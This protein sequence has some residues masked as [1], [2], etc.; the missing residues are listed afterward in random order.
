MPSRPR[1][2]RERVPDLMKMTTTGIQPLGF[3]AD[4]LARLDA[5]SLLR[6][7]HS[8][9]SAQEPEVILDDGRRVLLLA[10][11]NYLGL[12]THPDVVEAAVNAARRWGAGSGSARLITGGVTPHDELE[13]RL[14]E[15]KGTDDAVVFS[16][17]YLAN[18]GT[19]AA[20]VGPGD[21]IFSDELNH[22]SII[23]GAR[24]SRADVHVYRH[25]NAGHLT[26]QLGTWRNSHP[27]SRALVV[28][29]SVFS[30]DGDIAPLGGLADACDRYGAI[31]MVDEA[32]ATGVI[33]P[34]GRGAVAHLE[35]NGRVPVIM[36]TLSKAL[37]A[38]GGFVSGSRELCDFL[39]N[40]ARAFIFDTAMPAPT[41]A[42]ASAA[43]DILAKE[44]ERAVRAR[45]LAT[46]LADKLRTVGFETPHPVAAIV[47][48]HVGSS[49]A[50]LQLA[51]SL[52][53]RGVLVPAIRPP[54]VPP[55]TARLR[56]TVMATH[57]DE[58]LSQAVS[59]F[60]GCR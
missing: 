54:T 26:D 47:P 33:G 52:M 50:A 41:A 36:G 49:E 53:D 6:K 25:A 38:A 43:L 37:G 39:R 46:Q 11:N 20:L 35:L 34:R 3:C 23:D 28:S 48:V 21:A 42:A 12:A 31:L 30:M 18:L 60:A 51:G 56:A 24:L 55:G 27:D 16:S 1:S 10:S 19:I 59:A 14:A 4:E 40:K 29:D 44:P 8:L 22:A 2:Q 57:T 9:R 32:H 7:V 13:A 5:D 45:A 58:Q 15:L 17:G